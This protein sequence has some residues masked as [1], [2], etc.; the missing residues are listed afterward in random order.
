MVLNNFKKIIV[1]F[2][3]LLVFSLIAV[4]CA[5]GEV[6]MAESTSDS[7]AEEVSSIEET[8]STK[9]PESEYVGE[10]VLRT[11]DSER[12]YSFDLKDDKSIIIEELYVDEGFVASGTWKIGWD[13]VEIEI[14]ELFD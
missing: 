2:T 8:E 14:D 11:A 1:I 3:S 12:L 6:S 5:P 4:S 13:I 9:Y 7:S 10:Y